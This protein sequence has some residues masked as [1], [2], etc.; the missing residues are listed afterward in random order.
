MPD[1]VA[2]EKAG[3]SR[4]PSLVRFNEGQVAQLR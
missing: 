1:A 4:R 3:Q 2:V